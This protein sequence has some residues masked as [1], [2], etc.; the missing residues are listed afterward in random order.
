MYKRQ[1]LR[2]QRQF[3]LLLENASQIII[4]ARVEANIYTSS[5][6]SI[7]TTKRLKDDL[8][9]YGRRIS[10]NAGV[11]HLHRFRLIDFLH[12]S[13]HNLREESARRS[14]RHLFHSLRK[15]KSRTGDEAR[16][17]RDT[18]CF[19]PEGRRKGKRKGSE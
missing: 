3:Q 19:L 17:E 8:E 1:L 16:H 10:Q 12:E 15:G 13:R 7:R 6:T 18:R 5:H 4:C 11:S 9:C 2:C 14:C